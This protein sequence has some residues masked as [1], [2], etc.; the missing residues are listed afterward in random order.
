[1]S[2]EKQRRKEQKKRDRAKR[3]VA[4]EKRRRLRAAKDGPDQKEQF[5]DP[6][7]TG[8]FGES[9]PG[10]PT[11]EDSAI[12]QWWE[13]YSKAGE[14]QRLSM[15]RD[16]LSDPLD[17]QWRE[18]LFPEAVFE[19]ER[20]SDLSDY[21]ALLENLAAEHREL[22][23]TGLPWF[24]QSRI[25]H[26]LAVGDHEKIASAV[27]QDAAD[28][29]EVKEPYFALMSTLRLAGLDG[30]ADELATAGLNALSEGELMPWAENELFHSR[31]DAHVRRCV[32]AGGDAKAIEEMEHI[33]EEHGAN[34]DADVVL[35]RAEMIRRL[36]GRTKT[37][38]SRDQ[39]LGADQESHENRNLLSFEFSRWLVA[40]RQIAPI[41]A[42]ELRGLVLETLDHDKLTMQSYLN[43]LPKSALDAHLAGFLS[44][45]SLA[46]FKAPATL[47]AVE[48]FVAFL[49][50]AGLLSSKSLQRSLKTIR[51]LDETL[52]R[53][54][55]EEWSSFAFLDPLR[56]PS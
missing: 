50:E 54:L 49:D 14:K 47:I 2:S 19:A 36:S 48:H 11:P 34:M 46:R 37:K 9:S 53:V 3:A 39:L 24:L 42:D 31:M 33:L 23:D 41:A 12:D 51:E 43:G 1:M 40:Q 28:V 26:Y 10:A 45:M 29:N 32:A 21:V 18:A 27:R 38:W 25:R 17:D 15:V 44:F 35:L 7:H 6:G 8:I 20:A 4:K 13:R 5:A 16:K 56:P 22:Y 55:S 30:P 52:R